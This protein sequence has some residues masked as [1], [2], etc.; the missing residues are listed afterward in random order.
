MERETELANKF[1]ETAQ[2]YAVFAKRVLEKQ[3]ILM[4]NIEMLQQ[5]I[6]KKRDELLIEFSELKK[7]QIA[8]EQQQTAAAL[9]VKRRDDLL[10]DEA[11]IRGFI[12]KEP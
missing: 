4:R 8:L 12:R 6:D 11:A 1:P 9:E 2:A 5:A 10:M 3:K 7:Y